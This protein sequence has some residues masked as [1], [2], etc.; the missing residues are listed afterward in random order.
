MQASSGSSKMDVCLSEVRAMILLSLPYPPLPVLAGRV[1]SDEARV[2][3][4]TVTTSHT[5]LARCLQGAVQR[6]DRAGDSERREKQQEVLQRFLHEMATVGFF[7]GPETVYAI[8][9]K[10]TRDH[11]QTYFP[12]GHNLDLSFCPLDSVSRGGR[13]HKKMAEYLAAQCILFEDPTLTPTE[14]FERLEYP[15]QLLLVRAR[16]GHA[17]TQEERARI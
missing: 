13:A 7:E 14:E 8:Y 2:N 10:Y 3:G 1:E 12:K 17:M 11:L 5:F 6:C 16:L 4:E 9:C 15:A